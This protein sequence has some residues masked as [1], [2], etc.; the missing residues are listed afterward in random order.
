MKHRSEAGCRVWVISDVHADYPDNFN[1]LVEFARLGHRLDALIVAG[2]VT[3]KLDRLQQLFEVVVPCFHRVLFVPG[4]HELWVRREEF[5]DSLQKF[6]AVMDL[7]QRCGVQTSPV[8]IGQH[9]QVWLVPLQSWY[10]DKQDPEHSLFL[11]KSADDRTDQMWGDFYH[12]RWPATLDETLAAHFTRLNEPF[13]DWNFDAPVI[14]FSHFLP[15][16]ELVFNRH[17]E[18]HELVK[19]FDPFPEFNFTRVAGST[20][21]LRQIERLGSV[22]HVYGHQHRNR[23]RVLDGVTYVSH[24]MGYPKE[25]MLGHIQAD[26]MTPRCIWREDTG[27]CL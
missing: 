2:D 18:Q 14:S 8:K 6:D 10:D 17:Y 12:T 20:R 26:A 19:L 1:L 16:Q 22:V 9:R 23:V 27:F 15:R 4:N 21:I 13:L 7:C 25:R 24:C 5:A 3:D 11:P